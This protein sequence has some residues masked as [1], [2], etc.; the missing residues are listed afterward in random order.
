VTRR[1]SFAMHAES[2]SSPRPLVTISL[3]TY[4]GQ[5]WL[6][7]CLASVQAQD[8]THH[9]LLVLDNGST[10]GTIELLRRHQAQEPRMR[11][12]ESP[13][14]LGFAGGHNRNIAVARGE[15]VLLLNQDVELD[16]GFLKAALTAIEEEPEVGAVQG[17]L[18]RL[19][20]IGERTNIIDSTGLVWQRD[21]RVVSRRQGEHES[22]SDLHSGRVWGADGP[23]PFYR[24]AA[25]LDAQVP[26]PGGGWEVLDED[27]FMYKEDVDL[28]WRLRLLGWQTSYVPEALG[29]HARTAGGGPA[30]TMLDIARTSRTI[31]RWIKVISWR[32][33]RLMQVKNERFGRYLLDLP[34][35]MAREMLSLGFIVLT[36]PLRLIAIAQLVRMLPRALRKRRY[37][38]SLIRAGRGM[39]RAGASIEPS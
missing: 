27:F 36:D 34:W 33:Q 7:G 20:Q 2:A 28:A 10:D 11:L 24:R 32:N 9:E 1:S 21:H 23:A 4:N 19:S 25:L 39:S 22:D 8:L 38:S 17:R 16:V 35:I 29:W 37:I 15:Y 6:P 14:N 26:R 12:E 18:R 30:R 5:R 3:V 13:A 31:P